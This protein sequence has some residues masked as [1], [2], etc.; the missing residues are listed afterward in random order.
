MIILVLSE[1]VQDSSASLPIPPPLIPKNELSVPDNE[2]CD[3]PLNLTTK[4]HGCVG[5]GGRPFDISSIVKPGK[6][7]L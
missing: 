5:N 4:K 2:D 6:C 3:Q 1:R 7:I